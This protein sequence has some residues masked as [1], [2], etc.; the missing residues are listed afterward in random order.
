M[1]SEAK[2]AFAGSEAAERLRTWD[3]R[4]LKKSKWKRSLGRL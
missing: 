2:S 3:L 1:L 4:G